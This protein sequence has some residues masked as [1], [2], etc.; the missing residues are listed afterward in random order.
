MSRGRKEAEP[1]AADGLDAAR[2]L[3][4]L[5]A[6]VFHILLALLEAPRHGYAIMQEVADRTAGEVRLL[7]GALYR[8]L[9]RLRSDGVIEEIGESDE[10]RRRSY[11]VTSF[12]R[13]VAEAEASRLTKLV[14][15]AVG[16]DLVKGWAK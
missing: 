13:R 15:A 3:L 10:S 2:A 9:D 6:E 16:R 11:R 1:A 7:P 5:K 8:H 12:G 14:E 4:P